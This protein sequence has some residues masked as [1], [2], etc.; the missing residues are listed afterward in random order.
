MTPE[1][2]T[3]RRAGDADVP[4]LARLRRAWVAE[5][6]SPGRDASRDEGAESRAHAS[7]ESAP[8][9]APPLEQ[10]G[11]P[12]TDPGFEATFAEWYAA[13]RG[14]RVNWVAE[15]S[16]DPVGMLNLVVF[17]RM[18]K[19]GR[20]VSQWGYV[21]NVFVLAAYRNQGVGARLLNAAMSH[22]AEHDFV[23]VVLS[24]SERSVPFYRRAGFV[25]PDMLLVHPAPSRS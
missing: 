18:P 16:G 14:R 7:S 20:A 5:V 15:I 3:V 9:Q 19:P 25:E 6:P 8:S 21:S 11:G 4:L 2:A 24:P 17:R 13:E 12:V 1:P 23:R 22:A 10:Q